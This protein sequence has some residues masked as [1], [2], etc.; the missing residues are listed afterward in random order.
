MSHRCDGITG[1]CYVIFKCILCRNL[2]GCSRN[3]SIKFL[4]RNR[5][6]SRSEL[7]EC[8]IYFISVFRSEAVSEL[9]NYAENR[10]FCIVRRKSVI[11]RFLSGCK[12]ECC[13]SRCRRNTESVYKA[14]HSLHRGRGNIT[15]YS[16][17]LTLACDDSANVLKRRCVNRVCRS[18]DLS[19][20]M[21]KGSYR[22]C[23]SH[24]QFIGA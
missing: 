6:L 22:A 13:F 20:T 10:L 1:I 17:A 8:F 2:H 18:L 11:N 14:D 4:G 5:F 23:I 9:F 3:D 24:C 19:R 15:S 12:T 21:T 16:K 7:H